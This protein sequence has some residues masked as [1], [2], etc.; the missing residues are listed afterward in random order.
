M[1]LVK[2]IPPYNK[3]TGVTVDRIEAQTVGELLNK[4]IDKYG[5][6]MSSLLDENGELSGKHVVMVDRRSALTLQGSATPLT[7]QSE[8]IIMEYLGWA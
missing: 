1:A 7:A 8:V 2:F 3:I 4:I 5:G 6:E